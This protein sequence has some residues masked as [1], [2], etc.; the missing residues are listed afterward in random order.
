MRE[1]RARFPIHFILIGIVLLYAVGLIV[2]P[3]T[4]LFQDA[5]SKGITPLVNALTQQ[6]VIHA[7][8]L[9]ILLSAGATAIN[10]IGGVTLA[11]VLVRQSFFGKRLCMALINMP[12]AISPV[13]VGYILLVI[14]GRGGWLNVPNVAYAIPGMLLATVIVAMP[15]V[16]REV[17][18]ILAA[19]GPE[20]EEGAY[21]LGAS[22]WLT[23]RRIIFPRIRLAVLYGAAL[24]VA[25][26]LGEFGAVIVI[27]GAIQ[28]LT[29]TGTVYVYRA[30]DIR[31]NVGAYGAA[32]LLGLLSV[33]L[34]IG[35]DRFRQRAERAQGL[36]VENEENDVD[37]GS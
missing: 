27:G 13:I 33:I 28:G 9:T 26:S 11:W 22:R 36:T 3:L 34:L 2:A 18:P 32:I 25:R 1:Q 15:F 17:M 23:F 12:F 24:T 8:G 7:F 21:T 37:S 14:F 6:D 10:L 29:E 19:L 16:V 5:F 20:Q 4:V 35:M 31:G 30:L